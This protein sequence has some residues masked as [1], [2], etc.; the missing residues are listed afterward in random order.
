[1][2]LATISLTNFRCFERLELNGLERLVIFIGENDAGKTVLLDAVELLVSPQS[3]AEKDCR[4]LPDNSHALEVILEG[5]FLL[6]PHD[7]LPEEYRCGEHKDTLRLRKR[8]TE[9][10][11]EIYVTGQGYSD[12]RFDNFNGADNQ[13]SLLREYGIP[14]ASNDTLRKEQLAGLVG[15]GKLTYV[16]RERKLANFSALAPHMPRVERIASGEYRSP[17]SMIQRTLQTVAAS[18]IKPINPETGS[19]ELLDSLVEVQRQIEQ[20]L[21][22]EIERAKDTL[23]RDHQRLQSISVSPSID[24]TRAVT[25]TNL[26]LDLGDG[27]RLLDMFGDGTKR[28]MW[29]GLLEWERQ[30][31]RDNVSGSVIRLYDEPDVNLHYEAQRQLFSNIHEMATNPELRAQCFLCTHS[32]TLIDRAPSSA[33]NLIRVDE[34]NGRRIRRIQSSD[35]GDGV[36]QFFNE[37]GRAVGLSNTVLLYERGFFVV[38]GESEEDSIP[39][40]YRTLF[41]RSMSEDGL[42]LINLHNCSA[43][44]A[45]IS[46]LL[47]NRMEMTHFLLDADC[48]QP[49]SDAYI[50]PELLAEFG[51][52]DEFLREQITYIGDKEYED[53]FEVDLIA[54]A[55]NEDFP[56]E[57]ETVWEP[58]MLQQLKE[59]SSKFSEDLMRTVRRTCVRRL[60]SNA[61]KPNI[62]VAMAKRCGDTS[63]PTALRSA[64]HSLRHRVG[65]IPQQ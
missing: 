41:G 62:A 55:L 18:V 3:C 34:A 7:A 46:T 12:E 57:D 51:C 63:V 17:D 23:R 24:F 11:T 25:T 58:E 60:R 6:E 47:K 45:V 35:E 53:A 19:P 32:V 44:K 43:W 29:M 26:R 48:Q 54:R 4:K 28:R 61:T 1:M 39:L 64:L 37:I 20:R 5:V 42:V 52:G 16:E 30:A 27:E 50:T 10:G 2:I 38:E 36:I 56:K 33:I 31:T 22:E 49:D 8:F 59:A 21:N 15:D 40:V 14:P 9:G 13:K 65:I